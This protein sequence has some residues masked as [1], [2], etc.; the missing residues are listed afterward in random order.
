[1][2]SKGCYTGI[3]DAPTTES[4][5]RNQKWFGPGGPI[6][7][8]PYLMGWYRFDEG[9]GLVCKNSATDGSLGG[10]LLPDLT[11]D[12]LDGTFWSFFPGFAS[13]Q[14]LASPL[15]APY[16]Y[17]TFT[18]RTFGGSINGYACW[19]MFYRRCVDINI[20]NLAV[21]LHLYDSSGAKGTIEVY[22]GLNDPANMSVGALWPEYSSI[23][24]T[25]FPKLA[26]YFIFLAD[27]KLCIARSDG[28]LEQGVAGLYTSSISLDGIFAGAYY[29]NSPR[30]AGSY[31]DLIVYNYRML[32]LEEWGQWYDDV[33]DRYGMATRVW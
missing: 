1:M 21:Q 14:Y 18:T 17:A 15:S 12:N 4:L 11:V 22:N 24:D 31:G 19:G 29:L 7:A 8:E 26:W 20:G 28:T 32:T 2:R 30:A 33:R 16:A 27:R 10:G 5:M 6:D 25:V 23:G 13:T 3:G 9:T